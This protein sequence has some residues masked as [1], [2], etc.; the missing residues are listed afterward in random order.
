[1]LRN[2]TI[3]KVAYFFGMSRIS[4]TEIRDPLLR[5][6]CVAPISEVHTAAM[7]ELL[8]AEY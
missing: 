7:F 2:N 3:T 8:M 5:G 1:M 4:H 6:I